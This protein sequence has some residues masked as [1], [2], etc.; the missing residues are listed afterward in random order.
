MAAPVSKDK[1][2]ELLNASAGIRKRQLHNIPASVA[3]HMT[4]ESL[5]VLESFGLDAP[6][7]LNQ[8]AC[9]VEDALIDSVNRAAKLQEA[10]LVLSDEVTRLRELTSDLSN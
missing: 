9:S 3:E 1:L 4:E 7:L 5:E 2:N 6:H 10:L 8:Y